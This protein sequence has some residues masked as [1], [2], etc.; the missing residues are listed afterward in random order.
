MGIKEDALELLAKLYN[1]MTE[2]KLT[3]LDEIFESLDFSVTRFT[4][5]YAYLKEKNLI[6]E[7]VRNIGKT[8]KGLPDVIGL[9]INSLGIDSIEKE[10]VLKDNFSPLHIEINQNGH[11]NVVTQNKGPT[12]IPI[13][14][15]VP[16][17]PSRI[18][19][20]YAYP[21]DPENVVFLEKASI[22]VIGRYGERN[23]TIFGVISLASGLITIFG[24]LYSAPIEYVKTVGVIGVL[25]A[26]F[27]LSLMQLVSYKKRGHCPECGSDYSL[28]EV[29]DPTEREFEVRGGVRKTTYRTYECTNEDCDYSVE[30]KKNRFIPDSRF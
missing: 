18:A 5:A 6:T 26:I 8:A 30:R 20:P 2:G 23:T 22:I 19:D 21:V 25:L 16:P 10:D 11:V 29:G 15:P 4:N 27:G 28:K 3:D 17:T 9:R 1:N 24:A 14:A 7:K 12:V 13:T